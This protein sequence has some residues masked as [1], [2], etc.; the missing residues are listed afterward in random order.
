MAKGQKKKKN[1]ISNFFFSKFFFCLL[2]FIV[3]GQVLQVKGHY[4]FK[5]NAFMYLFS[6]LL[7]NNQFIYWKTMEK[8]DEKFQKNSRKQG[9]WPSIF[10]VFGF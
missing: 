7:Y 2:L 4:C 5:K 10:P 6:F 1:Q 3:S 9:L 8:V